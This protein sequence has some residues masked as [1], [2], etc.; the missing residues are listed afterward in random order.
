MAV[1]ESA[2][3]R[4]PG[5]RGGASCPLLKRRNQLPLLMTQLRGQGREEPRVLEDRAASP[6]QQQ[7]GEGTICWAKSQDTEVEPETL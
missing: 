1:V 7:T 5:L 4:A 6:C 2:Q 3:M